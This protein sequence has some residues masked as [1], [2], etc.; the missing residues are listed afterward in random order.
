VGVVVGYEQGPRGIRPAFVTDVDQVDRL[1]FDAACVHNLATYLSPRR[2]H[3][4]RLG[5]KAIV[6]KPCDVRAIAGLVR[7]HQLRREDVIIIGMRCPGVVQG[8]APADRCRTCT[9]REPALYDHLLGEAVTVTAQSSDRDAR[10]REIEGM[11]PAARWEYWQSELSRCVRCHAC[12]EVC[13]MCVCDRC[14]AQKTQP[15]W[16]ERSPH[17][18][19]N[20][21][22][23]MTRV[24]HQAGRCVD[25]GECERA[26]PVG[27]PLG[28]L[29]RKTAQVV[30]ARF[31]YQASDDPNAPTPIGAFQ[32]DDPQEFIL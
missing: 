8:D 6:A 28:L 25:C 5:K 31:G 2:K 22:W 4:T 13:P 27:I 15:Q 14:V 20:L 7:E 30:Q 17:P 23:Q 10:I 21:A 12:R 16:I 1:V 19:A 29:M 32:T 11:S 9:T 24:L 26:C 3:L 18:R